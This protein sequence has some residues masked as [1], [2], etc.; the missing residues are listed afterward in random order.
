[1][2]EVGYMAIYNNKKVNFHNSM[3]TKMKVSAEAF[4][5]GWQ[6]PWAKLWVEVK[7]DFMFV[8]YC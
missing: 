7:V 6:C 5:K 1:M 3:I 8:A 2:V 4:P